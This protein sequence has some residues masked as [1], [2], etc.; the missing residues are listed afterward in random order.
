MSGFG[1]YQRGKAISFPPASVQDA[2]IDGALERIRGRKVGDAPLPQEIRSDRLWLKNE[3]GAGIAAGAVLEVSTKLLTTITREN[4]WFSGVEPT[5]DYKKIWGVAL[6]QTPDDAIDEF[7]VSG[8]AWARV[9][10]NHVQHTHCDVVSGSTQLE[11][12][13]HGTAKIVQRA[14]ASTGVQDCLIRLGD[15]FMG[16]IKVVTTG[17]LAVDSSVSCTV[18]VANATSS[19]SDTITVH[20]NWITAGGNVATSKELFVWYHQDEKKYLP[21]SADC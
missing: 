15:P 5:E 9:D 10:I 13:W 14:T 8:L 21:H 6:R 16:P 3:S 7:Q 17:S 19:P 12:K 20:F 4:P 18:Y 11:S 2:I 1:R